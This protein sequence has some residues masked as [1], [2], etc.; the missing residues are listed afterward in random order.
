MDGAVESTP[1]RFLLDTGA[2]VSVIRRDMVPVDC[3]QH[4][5]LIDSS[6]VG[7]NGLPLEVVGQITMTV[8]LGK[9]TCDQQFIVVK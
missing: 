5:S 7:A 2:A 4:I 3:Q 9:F 8:S 6:P 1:T